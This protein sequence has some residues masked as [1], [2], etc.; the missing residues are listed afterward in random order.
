MILYLTS[1]VREAALDLKALRKK[2]NVSGAQAYRWIPAEASARRR[3]VSLSLHQENAG[4]AVALEPT[5]ELSF[6]AEPNGSPANLSSSEVVKHA[7]S[8]GALFDE[9]I[10]KIQN[11]K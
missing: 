5:G 9:H 11:P 2:I 7:A 3:L 4:D 6:S 10:F 1:E 8:P